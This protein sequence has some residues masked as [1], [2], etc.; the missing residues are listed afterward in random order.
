M[1]IRV[2]WEEAEE[3][4]AR[5]ERALDGDHGWGGAVAFDQ[6][7]ADVVGAAF[8]EPVGGFHGADVAV[9]V[10]VYDA[11]VVVFAGKEDGVVCFFFFC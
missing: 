10:E 6:P 11:R 1:L 5:G 4:V 2:Q 3:L 7:A 8:G 9:L